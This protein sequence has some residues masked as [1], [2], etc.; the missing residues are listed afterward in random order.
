MD[1]SDF[2]PKPLKISFSSCFCREALIPMFM[3]ILMG[4]ATNSINPFITLVVKER[5]IEGLSWYYTINAL[6]MVFIRPVVA[7][8]ADKY[9][10][11]KLLY[12]LLLVFMLD[13]WVLSRMTTTAELL[14][15]SVLM[16][17]GYSCSYSLIQSLAFTVSPK[18]RRGAAGSTCY[19]G[20]DL[21]SMLGG[22]VGGA[23]AES[24][25]YTNV[26][27][28]AAIPIAMQIMVLY[29]WMKKAGGV[30]VH[31]DNNA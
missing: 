27:R 31:S 29:A 22:V 4:I 14:L 24:Y 7:R 15:C 28:F 26:F 9:G 23:I 11:N 3:L 16:G 20:M 30:P 18:D 13:T 21:G 5:E 17:I 8:M 10:Q 25:G 2:E 6:V 1:Y 19:I 12:P